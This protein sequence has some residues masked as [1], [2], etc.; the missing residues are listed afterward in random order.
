[1][2]KVK[3]QRRGDSGII[4]PARIRFYAKSIDAK[5]DGG[6]FD[7]HTH[8]TLVRISFTTDITRSVRVNRCLLCQWAHE[9]VHQDSV[10]LAIESRLISQILLSMSSNLL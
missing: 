6:L 7:F 4:I 5:T 10:Y 3:T 1:M 8:S 2:V 9:T